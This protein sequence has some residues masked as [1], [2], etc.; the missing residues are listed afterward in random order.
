[1]EK[2]PAKEKS[3]I[4]PTWPSFRG[5]GKLLVLVDPGDKVTVGI[6]DVDFVRWVYRLSGSTLLFET[7]LEFSVALDEALRSC[8]IEVVGS[9]EAESVAII[10]F[11]RTTLA[12]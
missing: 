9:S 8:V 12:C 7:K 11:E 2:W 3:G 10:G 1:M 5:V 6:A 4:R